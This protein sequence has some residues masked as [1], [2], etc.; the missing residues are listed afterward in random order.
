MNYIIVS[1]FKHFNCSPYVYHHDL[2]LRGI[3]I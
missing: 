3:R 2:I 1:C